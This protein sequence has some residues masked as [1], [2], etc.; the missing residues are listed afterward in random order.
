MELVTKTNGTISYLNEDII[1]FKKG[2][3]GFENL[4]KFLLVPVEENDV[5]SILQSIE[6]TSV[7]IVVAS[8]L[9]LIDEYNIEIQES[10]RKDLNIENDSD[11]YVFNTITLNSDIKKITSNLK[12]P[13]II[14]IKDKLG[15]Q[16]ILNDDKYEIKHP[17][18]KE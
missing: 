15:E 9:N 8:P 6:D 13:I 12:A 14:N 11:A 1:Q 2:L 10:I 16:I 18:F 7:G 5:F 17:L 3:P 4:T